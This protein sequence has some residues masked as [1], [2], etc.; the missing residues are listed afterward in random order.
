MNSEKLMKI[1]EML[2]ALNPDTQSWD[3]DPFSFQESLKR[4]LFHSRI[5]INQA[6]VLE[7]NGLIVK[8]IPDTIDFNM[9]NIRK[10]FL[11]H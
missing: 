10:K 7:D 1:A 4:N 6:S 9:W 8:K 3:G 2:Y 11:K 5:A